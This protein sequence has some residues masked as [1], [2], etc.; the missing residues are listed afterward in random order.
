ML[1]RLLLL[2]CAAIF[3]VPL[4]GQPVSLSGRAVDYAG[5]ELV[6]YTFPEPISHRQLKL[7]ATRVAPDGSFSLSF[8]TEQSIEIYVD[9]EKFRGSLVAEPHTRYQITLPPFSPRT[10]Q[11][12]A[13]PY[14]EPELYWLGLK[15]DQ[16][17][18]INFLVRDFLT[19]YNRELNTHTLDIYQKKSADTAK[20]IIARLEKK[21]PAGNVHYLN[22][23]QTYSYGE[24][25][26]AVAR[27]E[28]ER[29]AKKY[30]ATRAVALSHPAYQHL[31]NA[32]YTDYLT[33]QSQDIRQKE[34]IKPALQG[35]F[36]GWTARMT[37]NG[38]SREVA[39]LVAVKSFYDGYFS[40]KFNKPA[41]L[42]GLKE[43]LT[44]VTY[45]PLRELLPGIVSKITS[46]QEGS[47]A[48]AL[49]LKNLK[50]T[51][52]PLQTKGKFVYL[53]F[54]RSDSKESRTELDT[55]ALLDK[56]LKTILTVVPVSLDENSAD[57]VKFWNTKNYPWELAT[58]ADREK[59]IQ[60][61]RIKTVPTFYLIAPNQ[62]LLLSPAL[63][64]NHNFEALFLKVY[65]EQRFV[66]QGRN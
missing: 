30:F 41:M 55:L 40:G 46:L 28:R 60:D 8:Q 7:A 39:E 66:Q 26:Y 17:S 22:T 14:F 54:F 1:G 63:S 64:P 42:K 65:R 23:L 9:L 61:Y 18:D 45:A 36:E 53:A 34:G 12:A 13:S 59:A 43:A 49:L 58:A 21:Y 62:Q 44:H 29:T 57:A 56:K 3:F 38:Y 20:A 16:A 11:E 48:P 32:L 6:F 50:N 51:T 37:S 47:P 33:L 10:R 5:K 25:E 4:F 31:F 19:E 52:A 24:L 27:P 15:T 2:F 35:N